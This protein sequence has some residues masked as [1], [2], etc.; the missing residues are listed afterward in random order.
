[1]KVMLNKL[2]ETKNDILP[3]LLRLTLGLVIFPHGAQKLFGW[4]GGYG[5]NGMM[6]WFTETMGIPAALAFL[7][8]MAESLGAVALIAGLF[9]RVMAFGIGASL[10]GAAVMV[11]AQNGFFMNWFGNQAGEGIEYS[12]LVIGISIALMIRGGGAYSLDYLFQQKLR[13]TVDVRQSA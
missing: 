4:F 9:S 6:Q 1:M 12:L 5:L 11:Q 10:A 2:I 13:H 7:V 3:L 8:I